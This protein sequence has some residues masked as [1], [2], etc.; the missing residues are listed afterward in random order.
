MSSKIDACQIG[1]ESV[2]RLIDVR[3]SDVIGMSAPA[4]GRKLHNYIA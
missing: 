2:M 1:I 3:F 4:Q